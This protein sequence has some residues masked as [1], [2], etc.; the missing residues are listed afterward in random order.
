M[1]ALGALK[2]WQ[3]AQPG[4]LIHYGTHTI[5]LCDGARSVIAAGA[6]IEAAAA[7][8]LEEWHDQPEPAA[9]TAGTSGV[10]ASSTG[11]EQQL[12]LRWAT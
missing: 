4:R 12:G 10:A 8:A 9:P 5:A 6:D 7:H 2:R 11:A 1:T 3:R